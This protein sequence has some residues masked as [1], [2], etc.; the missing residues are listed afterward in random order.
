MSATAAM[1]VKR[2]N[3]Q[4][5]AAH[6]EWQARVAA[7]AEVLRRDRDGAVLM[8]QSSIASPLHLLEPEMMKYI[9]KQTNKCD[10]AGDLSS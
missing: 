4:T 7:T 3:F 8:G 9:I 1:V 5:K 2:R 10:D 6:A